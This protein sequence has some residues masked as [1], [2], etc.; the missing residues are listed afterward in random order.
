M[1]VP[2]QTN[3]FGDASLA[4]AVY[5]QVRPVVPEGRAPEITIDTSLFELGLDSIARMEVVHRLEEAFSIRFPEES[6]YEL[7]TCRDLV[8]CVAELVEACEQSVADVA[9]PAPPVEYPPG[10]ISAEATDV[11]TF[12]EC[13][14]VESRLSAAA[15]AGYDI[16]FF[17]T[18]QRVSHGIS[19]IDGSATVCFT[20][21]DY[22]GLSGDPEVA[23]AAKRAIDRFGTSASASRLVGGET[24]ILQ[25]LDTAIAR[26]VGTEAAAVFPSGYGTNASLFGH[27]FGEED[28]ILY[29]D[30]AHN[31]IV[32]GTRL[33]EART[34]PFPHNNL[35]FLDKLL[36]DVRRKY[37][38]VV[39]AVEGVYSMDGDFPDLPRLVEIKKR[40]GALLY[41]DEAHSIGVMGAGGR[42]ICEHFDVSPAEGDFWMGTIS[43]A[44][45]SQGGYIAGRRSLVRYLK[46]TTPSFVFSTANSPANSAAALAAIRLLEQQ[47]ERVA[48]LQAR[49]RLFNQLAAGAG[50]DVGTSR[51]TPVVPVILGDSLKC[52]R[53]SQQL[54][55]RGI[56]A[57]PILYPAVPEKAARLR[58][59]ITANHTEEQI[60]RTVE[61]LGECVMGAGR[62]IMPRSRIDVSTRAA[63]GRNSSV[64]RRPAGSLRRPRRVS[65]PR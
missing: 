35:A 43:K 1:S 26:L 57:Q 42:G 33:S 3:I 12:P 29:D 65:T 9:Q 51:N 36:A 49:A 60:R 10:E 47:P 34:R 14:G 25:E 46:Y 32:Q 52:V 28:L 6:L 24:T 11:T 62:P 18:K 17:R 8:E 37:R 20:S 27:L 2:S 44:L 30:L 21:F 53:V 23:A 59:F 40:H 41:V 31:S 39:V 7:E 63:L 15:A 4:E 45:A 56:D 38:R 55:E 64:R 61:M 50:F 16:P 22:L 58:F 13:V 19:T 48:R 54:L 5:Q